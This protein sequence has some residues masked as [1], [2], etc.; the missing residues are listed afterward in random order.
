MRIR[1]F[2]V[3]EDGGAVTLL[4][5]Y[6]D[7]NVSNPV[8]ENL[9]TGDLREEPKLAGEGVAVSVHLVISMSD[10]KSGGN[11]AVLECIPGVGR[12]LIGPFINYLLRKGSNYTFK[13]ENGVDQKCRPKVYFEALASQ[14]LKDDLDNGALKEFQ[15][16][17]YKKAIK[18]FDQDDEIEPLSS[19]VA[20]SVKKAFK[21]DAA[22]SLMDRIRKKGKKEGYSEIRVRLKNKWGKERTIS[23]GVSKNDAQSIAYGKY[24]FVSTAEVIKQCTHEIHGE[25]NKKMKKMLMK[26]VSREGES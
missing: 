17:K 9:E 7:K 4:I 6:S 25:L 5:N 14:E 10:S 26:E 21:S 13:N 20:L 1:D 23:F 22:F 11:L 19:T 24:D 2:I 18:D 8:F 16:V 3:D 15:L 12:G